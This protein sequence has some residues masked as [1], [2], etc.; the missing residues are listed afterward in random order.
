M[1]RNDPLLSARFKELAEPNCSYYGV[2][3]QQTC[4]MYW[5]ALDVNPSSA[6]AYIADFVALVLAKPDSLLV[7]NM[8]IPELRHLDNP[9][10]C[11]NPLK[12]QIIH[13]L[14]LAQP[15]KAQPTNVYDETR[16]LY[17]EEL[18][19]VQEADMYRAGLLLYNR[20]NL[21]RQEQDSVRAWLQA[22]PSSEGTV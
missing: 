19:I 17:K 21:S 7:A 4:E 8:V 20:G 15:S 22:A 3:L 6:S 9:A 2:K 16:R 11:T 1:S 10:R 14:Q 12:D 13:Q 5:D 18:G